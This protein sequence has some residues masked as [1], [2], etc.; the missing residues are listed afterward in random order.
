[1]KYN[2]TKKTLWDFFF[3]LDFETTHHLGL[4]TGQTQIGIV[5]IPT[6]LVIPCFQSARFYTNY[7]FQTPCIWIPKK[8]ELYAIKW[9]IHIEFSSNI[10]FF[11][12]IDFLYFHW[13][14]KD[15]SKLVK[16]NLFIAI[17]TFIFLPFTKLSKLG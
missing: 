8:K 7:F 6:W 4:P 2:M 13:C 1:M 17:E 15:N 10:H 9:E 12:Q 14:L 5:G 11:F 3:F 16:S